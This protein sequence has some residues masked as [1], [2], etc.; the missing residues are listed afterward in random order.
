[1]TGR[2]YGLL[3]SLVLDNGRRW[4]DVAEGWQREGAL[5]VLGGEG[6]RRHIDTRPKGASKSTDAAALAVAVLRTQAPAL[7]ESYVL[8][9]D[10]EQAERIVTKVRG[11]ER[12]TPELRGQLRVDAAKVTA[13]NGAALMAL[14]SDEAGNQGLLPYFA[15][16]DEVSNWPDAGRRRWASLLAELPKVPGSRFLA[17]SHAGDPAHWFAAEV[18]RARA[19]ARMWAV[20]ETPGP[21]SWLSADEVA[22][23]R[24]SMPAWEFARKV[25]NRWVSAGG[26]LVDAAALR[27]CVRDDSEPLGYEPRRV[28]YVVGVDVGLVNDRTVAAVCHAERLEAAPAAW[29]GVPYEV[30]ATRVV[31]DR[32]AVWQGEP[33]APVRLSAVEDWLA[34]TWK[35]Y[36]GARVVFDPYQAVGTAQRLAA[37]GL[38]VEQFA[39]TTASTGRLAST[40]HMLL[41]NR[42]LS[43]P[44]DPE[45]LDELAH[46]RLVERSPG[47]VRM[48]HEPGRHDDRAIALA[49]AAVALLDTPRS[50]PGIVVADAGLEFTA[51]LLAAGF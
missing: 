31:L 23:L 7:S 12:R 19:N 3:C 1:M 40:L 14:A 35:L 39:F 6:P 42:A 51:D 43:L 5:A 20:R 18:E 8:A 28:P 32:L 16:A 17:I 47:I 44:D 25:E 21:L 4:G 37:R 46:V 22:E 10:A 9:A 2:A 48:D 13:P 49:L 41:R 36:G 38:H 45:L 15:V 11:F 34:E 29:V 26:R 24:A 30:N 33:G 50:G 27:E